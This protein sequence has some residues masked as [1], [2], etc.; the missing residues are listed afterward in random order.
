MTR[1]MS[2]LAPV[3]LALVIAT[4]AGLAVQAMC[5]RRD[6]RRYPATGTFIDGLHVRTAGDAGPAV[7]FEAGIAATGLNWV[8]VQEL[9]APHAR[10]CSYDRAGLG[11]SRAAC[12]RR[13]LAGMTADLHTVIHGVGWTQPVVLVGHSFGTF[14]VRVYAHRFPE[15]VA[16]LV[17]IGPVMPEDFDAPPWRTRVRLRRA[18]FFAHVTGICASFGLARL[19]L[20][21]LLRRGGGNAG[22]LLGLSS[23][24]RRV[25]AEVAKLPPETVR[26]LR[27]RWSEARFYRELAAS[28]L[29]LPACAAEARRQPVPA[30][31]PIV[32]L[33]GA[34][35]SADRLRAHEALA[36]RH[37][38][39]DGSAH[40]IHLDQP[41]LVAQIVLDADTTNRGDRGRAGLEP[42][43]RP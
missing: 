24:L 16:A 23:T 2:V 15:D 12:G 29:A 33:S 10:S 43:L 41:A 1:Y 31:I 6:R 14:I 25:A 7:V 42:G 20:W 27:T 3:T 30:G 9:L 36:T 34:H 22:P 13:S 32:I 38:V 18:A 21:G 35:Q 40:W 5:V 11:W 39:V 19:G 4:L 17:L 8:R 28:V 37:V 26:L